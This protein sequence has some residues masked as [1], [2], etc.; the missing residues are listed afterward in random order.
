M[1][2]LIG[3]RNAFGL[4]I[5]GK[6]GKPLQIFCRRTI[7]FDI[8]LLLDLNLLL[9]EVELDVPLQGRALIHLCVF[10]SLCC[11]VMPFVTENE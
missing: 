5:L 6:T 7:R 10:L 9:V 11:F 4:I 8:R 2:Q 3:N 1:W